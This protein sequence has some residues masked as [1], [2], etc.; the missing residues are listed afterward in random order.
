MYTPTWIRIPAGPSR[1]GSDPADDAVPYENEAPRH[2]VYVD[3]FQLTRTH[4]TNAQYAEFVRAAG[5]RAPAHWLNDQIPQGLADHPVVYVD[6]HDVMAFCQ[7]ANLRL[8][9]EAE[10]EKASRGEDARLWPWGNQPPDA[11]RC[12]FDKHIATTSPVHQ[13]PQSASPYGVLDLAGN[14]WE[15]TH[16]LARPYPYAAGDGRE[17]PLC[18]EARI[19][20][21][22]SYTHSA[23]EIRAADRHS[24]VAGTC[25]PYLGFRVARAHAAL[26][27]PLALEWVDIAAGE[28]QMGN[29][30]RRFRDLALPNEYPAHS[31]SLAE[32]FIA[33]TPVTNADYA[34]FVHAVAYAPPSHWLSGQIPAGREQHPVVNVSW[35]S[36]REFCQWADVRLSTEAE[37]EKAA[38]GANAR[39]V[40]VYPWGD[41]VPPMPCANYGKEVKTHSTTPVDQFPQGAS[42]YGVLDMAGNVW[43]WTSSLLADYPYCAD[44]GREDLSSRAHRVLRGG[45]FYSPST[46]YIRCA[47][48]SSSYP[49]RQRDHIGFRVAKK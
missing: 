47:S 19:V 6:W 35:D 10:W 40:R 3:A 4:V 20:R 49:Q 16:S 44:D 32:F 2:W 18:G 36:A 8:P 29:D 39:D 25:C 7:W 45:S 43:E 27:T 11:K 15:W 37:W 28:F 9:S 33:Q 31:L 21:G 34:L 46:S 17:D 30:P 14:V 48:R 5:H 1:M 24:F 23:R 22:G 42:P 41:E 13:F 12:N 26:P 38:R